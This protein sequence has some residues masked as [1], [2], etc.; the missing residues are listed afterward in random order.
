MKKRILV[1]LTAAM[2]L[3]AS[4]TGCGG[5]S[6]DVIKIGLTVPLSGDRASEGSYASN[7]AAIVEQEIN[8][9]GGV[10]GKQ[11]KIEIQDS[12][13]TDVGATNAYLKL[14][15]DDDVV[16]IIGPDNSND[17]IAIAGSAESAQVLTTGQGSSPTLQTTCEESEWMFQLRAC[18]STLCAALM[19]YAYNEVGAK[20]FTI[21]HDTETASTDQA[22]LFKN[23]IE[24]LGG[25]VDDVISYTSGTKDF[26]AQLTQAAEND[27]DAL[28]MACLYTEAAIIIQQTRDMGIDKPVF[29][30][31]A[32]GDPIAIDLA[33][34]AINDVYSVTA[35]VPNTPN[36]L[37]AA[38]SQK[39]TETYD[40][41]CAKAAAQVR[42]HVY[43][44]CEAIKNA[45][46]T[47]RAAVRDAMLELT[48]YEG[49]ITTYDC[50]RR[51]NCGL[52]GLI[53]QV[54]DQVPTIIKEITTG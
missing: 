17:N 43:V 42:D 29:G 1:C 2:L 14:A 7:A 53:V 41:D 39:Y 8:D 30:S 19:D 27:S 54:Q 21:I 24:E 26:T 32:F 37:G 16:A 31:N 51:G 52:G 11:I 49:A 48:D 18:D 15:A 40:E 28:V 13:G 10:L 50:S 3:A 22:N 6:S 44:I 46:T 4:L 36:P 25:T 20:S 38:F 5:G 9:A 12:L 23:A 33:G 34:D 47:D 35:W 45:G